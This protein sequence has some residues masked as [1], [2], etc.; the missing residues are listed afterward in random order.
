MSSQALTT[1]LGYPAQVAAVLAAIEPAEGDLAFAWLEQWTKQID[2]PFLLSLEKTT[3]MA[4]QLAS[5]M[6][7]APRGAYAVEFMR[8]P[9][10]PTLPAAPLA[11]RLAA[12]LPFD[13][14]D[15][16]QDTLREHGYSL[17]LLDDL[18]VSLGR[19]H[20]RRQAPAEQVVLQRPEPPAERVQVVHLAPG[21]WRD[22]LNH[23]IESGQ[24]SRRE[25]A[26]YLHSLSADV[27]GAGQPPSDWA[28][29]EAV[30]VLYRDKGH[31]YGNQE[32]FVRWLRS[33]SAGRAMGLSQLSRATFHRWIKQYEQ[34]TEE[35]V[36]PGKG[37]RKRRQL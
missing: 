8:P 7:P 3:Q 18:E 5:S 17:G 15:M 6:A 32:D 13:S 37:S 21:D 28:Q 29:I 24:A 30:A 19:L 34:I 25:L 26:E 12:A 27:R 22:A 2:Q 10:P 1:L 16:V 20:E 31:M 11:V 14:M 35:I 36:R 23:A 9:P 33:S 4:A